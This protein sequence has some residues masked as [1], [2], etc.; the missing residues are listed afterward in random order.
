MG[1]EE[2]D[3]FSVLDERG[4]LF[5]LV[6]IVD[7]LVVLLVLA[8][9]V[10]GIA[11]V[12]GMDGDTESEEELDTRYVT[13]DLGEQPSFVAGAINVGDEFNSGELR[14]PGTITDVYRTPTENATHVMVR[15]TIEGT[16]T[17][18]EDDDSATF[19]I[20][21]EPI[22]LNERVPIETRGYE[23]EGVI[24]AVDESGESLPVQR[25]ELVVAS[26]VPIDLAAEINDG[27]EYRIPG[28]EVAAIES[29]TVYT[30]GDPDLRRVILGV[31]ALAI[32][33]DESLR[34]G[35]HLLRTGARFDFETDRY[36]LSGEVVRR[37][38]LEEPGEAATRTV[39][40]AV[41]NI[42]PERADAIEA[43]LT[44]STPDL[45]AAEIQSKQ[46][47]PARTVLES[48]DGSLRIGTHPQNVDV[49]LDI[50]LGVR[51]F[52]NGP[53][54]FRGEPLRAG[55]TLS[56]DFGEVRIDGDVVR[57]GE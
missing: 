32:E 49:D 14:P 2:D 9:V 20:D 4:R 53:T 15:A 27:D 6:N 46:V 54:R 25:T 51:T 34:F 17:P 19:E 23:T 7:L 38:T 22:R 24:T 40:V 52:E 21:G 47:E 26:V 39:T 28:G 44:E 36:D 30:T 35:E 43:G 55:D 50:E 5:G 3:G 12:T 29:S 10:A 18:A 48:D 8:V 16:V 1:E 45:L 33:E 37:G 31:S 56:F 41:E 42:R 13:I 11:L 57:I